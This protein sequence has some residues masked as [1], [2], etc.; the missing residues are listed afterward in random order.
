MRK[1]SI[2]RIGKFLEAL[3][4]LFGYSL[5]LIT[6]SILTSTIKI[7]GS[8]YGLYA[9]LATIIIF[10]LNKTIKPIIFIL[11]LPITGMTLGIFYPFINVLILKITDF[12]LGNHFETSGILSLFF[13]AI[14]IS[15][16]NIFMEGL[17]IKPVLNNGGKR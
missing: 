16:L 17:I 11:T 15:I 6:V 7:D 2:R 5:V 1:N 3:I 13:V 10:I 4:Y 12:I 14:L 9:L 8:Y